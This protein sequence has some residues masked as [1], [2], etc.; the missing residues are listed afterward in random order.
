MK[1]RR[2]GFGLYITL[3]LDALI[4]LVLFGGFYLALFYKG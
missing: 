4:A 1:N 3:A 2:S